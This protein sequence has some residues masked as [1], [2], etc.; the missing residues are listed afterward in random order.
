MSFDPSAPGGPEIEGVYTATVMT[1]IA[2][3][4]ETRSDTF[5]A[6]LWLGSTGTHGAFAGSYRIVASP[7]SGPVRG[8]FLDSDGRLL[9]TTLGDHARRLVGVTTLRA[10]YDWCEFPQL[11]LS[12]LLG[13]LA[14]DTL[15][16]S[17]QGSL[18]CVYDLGV[19]VRAHT[20]FSISIS[21]LR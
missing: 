15:R 7:D 4:L 19:P 11:G 9:I 5:A 10:L 17:A 8:E 12:P 21:A 1:R 18:P 6:T 2:N 3:E 20:D 13:Q 16:I 14:G